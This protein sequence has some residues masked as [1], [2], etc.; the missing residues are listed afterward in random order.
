[1]KK[2]T[3]IFLFLFSLCVQSQTISHSTSMTLGTTNVSC[4]NQNPPATSSDNTYYRFFKLSDFSI[5]GDWAV[6]SVQFGI[7]VLTIPTLPDGFPMKVRI[8]STTAIN[9]PTNYPTGYTQ[10]I[11]QNVIITNA[12]LL[13]IL[14]VPITALIPAGSNLLVTLE[15]GAQAANSG[16]RMIFS[17]NNLGQTAPSYLSSTACNILVPTETINVGA[18]FPDAHLVLSV[19]GVLATDEYLLE[20][21]SVYPN[22]SNGVFTIDL[23]STAIIEKVNL[24]DISGKQITIA[25]DSNNSFDISSYN[26]GIYLLNVQTSDGV[27]NRKLIKQ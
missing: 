16:N 26:S 17:A 27:L 10:I 21:A 2:I 4:G 11:S 12:N 7:Q 22:P 18:G 19:T 15:Y 9:F 14:S 24:T 1:M 25:L 5:T 8:Y 6:S 3:L 23:K 20:S 13:T